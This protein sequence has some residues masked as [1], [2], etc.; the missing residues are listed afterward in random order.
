MIAELRIAVE[1]GRVTELSAPPPLGAKV[2]AGRT[3]PTLVLV[4]TAA[5]LLEGDRLG[6][7]IRVG[8]GQ[9]LS[10][11]SVAAQ[12]AHPCPH[13]GSTALEVI[14]C[15]GPDASLDWWPEPLVVCAGADH[16][17]RV[18]LDLA[19]GARAR[20]VEEV[21]LGRSGED[22]RTAALRSSLR[23][24]VEQRPLLRDGLDTT[25]AGF[26][27]PAV[28]GPARYLGAAV[29]A[30]P[31]RPPPEPAGPDGRGAVLGR[32]EQP[33]WLELAGPGHL[34]RVLDTDPARG[35]AELAHRVGCR[36]PAS[37]TP[38]SARGATGATRP[39]R[40]VRAAACD[41]ANAEG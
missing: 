2:L 14:A 1:G 12:L 10:V 13:G 19:A 25:L 26:D 4:A 11:R 5:G 20:W 39:A 40:R 3:G 28:A 33:G 37:S 21:V 22:P 34:A 30:G 41:G 27:G 23:V 6:V 9:H 24:D 35:R 15:V 31:D 18:R 8:P 38:P 16:V 7:T 17:V 29:L 36:E 32:S